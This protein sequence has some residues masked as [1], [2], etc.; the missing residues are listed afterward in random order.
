MG[1][2]D[3]YDMLIRG[4]H[5][6]VAV[7]GGADSTALLHLLYSLRAELDIRLAVAHLN[8]GLRGPA[9][10]NDARFVKILAAEMAL[11]YHYKEIRLEPSSRG[12]LEEQGRQA[13]YAFFQKVMAQH[14]CT[15]IALA[16]H[17]DD[18]AEAVLMHLLRGS[19]IRGLAGIP[20]VR[21]GKIIRPLIDSSR[22]EI[23][24]FLERHNIPHVEDASNQDLRFER[25]R[26]RHHLLPLLRDRYN[27]NVVA[28]LHRTAGLCWQEEQWLQHHLGPLLGKTVSVSDQGVM[29]IDVQ[30][31]AAQP[32]AVQRRLVREGLRQWHGDLKRIRIN[33]IDKTIDLVKPQA[34]GKRLCLPHQIGVTRTPNE[35]C[36]AY[37]TGRG[38]SS[39]RATI[40]YYYEIAFPTE[41][42]IVV[43][44]P[45]TG[46]RFRF[47]YVPFCLRETQKAASTDTIYLDRNQ[48]TFPLTLRNF[49]PGDRI[50]LSGIQG[51]QKIKK[52]FNTLKIP[53]AQR[54]SVPL[55]LSGGC[56]VWVVGIRRSSLAI[57]H[58]RMTT[59][60]KVEVIHL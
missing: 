15:K 24:S 4:D 44:I 3:R 33:H 7:S 11:P 56:I 28:T 53:A 36:F 42:A 57:P 10:D 26:I 22:A 41:Q 2:I 29:T 55:L 32:M 43:E 30:R 45:E 52:M 27:T 54:H 6:L 17:M 16:H 20:P 38:F 19:G 51:H 23:M 58:S 5:V 14:N 47:S 39:P 8:H 48:L 50:L 21:D 12:S 1:T 35:L 13:R 37:R 31:L 46:H 49:R 40:N 34:V 25:N 18:N 59:A 60:I 9:S